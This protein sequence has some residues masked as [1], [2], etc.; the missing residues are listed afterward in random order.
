ME[1]IL[2]SIR[3]IIAE[4]GKADS[5]A[6][7]GASAKPAPQARSDQPR[8]EE[9]VLLLTDRVS[10]GPKRPP[11]EAVPSAPPAAAEPGLSSDTAQTVEDNFAALV[12]AMQRETGQQAEGRHSPLEPL[13]LEALRPALKD[14]LDRNLAPIV[15]RVVREEVRRLAKRA[16]AQ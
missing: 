6:E 1:E 16:E 13:V 7:E 8:T 11:A 5:K 12:R 4:D 14:W 10:E 2:T 9:D 15:E 3:R